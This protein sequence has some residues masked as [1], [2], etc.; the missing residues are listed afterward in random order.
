MR[1]CLLPTRAS[2]WCKGPEARQSAVGKLGREA[3]DP[4]GGGRLGWDGRAEG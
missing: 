4:E 3:R 2:S 1:A